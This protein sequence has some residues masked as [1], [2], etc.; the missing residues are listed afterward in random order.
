MVRLIDSHTHL[1]M[2]QF[3]KDLHGVIERARNSGVVAMIT[4]GISLDSSEK[5][6]EIARKYPF[7]Y[8][9]VGCH[10]HGAHDLPGEEMSRLKE[11]AMDPRVVA[12]GETGLDYY[13]DRAPRDKQRACLRQQVA[14]AR[15]CRLPL[16][17]HDRE[18][19]DDVIRILK[20]ESAQE[21]G[22]VI[23]CFS[24]DWNYAKKCLDLGFY[25]SVP[26]T[27]TYKNAEI[28]RE[29]VR[30][31]PLE[32]LMVE[33]DAP[34]LTPVPYRGKRNEPAYVVFTAK[35]VSELRNMPLDEISERLTENTV[36]LF[37]L[38]GL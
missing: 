13:R 5:A 28:Q 26:G 14:L 37:R 31:C 16:V 19:H 23:H 38:T 33:T 17:I 2:P 27:V 32:R 18:A 11:L 36:R 3:Q 29:V 20:D 12:W 30:K 6:L 22:G 21:V 1:D 9:T 4:V 35:K 24:G 8:S 15:E 7:I 34:Y 25:I 10:P